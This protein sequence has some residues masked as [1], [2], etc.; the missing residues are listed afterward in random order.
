MV[1]LIRCQL[2]LYNPFF[3]CHFSQLIPP[4]HSFINSRP[5]LQQNQNQRLE[6]SASYLMAAFLVIS[7]LLFCLI[8]TSNAASP[9]YNV[10]QFGAKPDG[11]TDSTQPFL[12]AWVAACTSVQ[13]AM[14]YV[15][16]GRYVIKAAEFRG[17]CKN[18]IT[19]RIDGTLVAPSDF[20]ALG[21]DDHWIL[22][23]DVDRLSV[24]G[25]SFDG[26]GAGLW[27]CRKSAQN[28]PAAARVRTS[29]NLYF[30]LIKYIIMCS[31]ILKRFMMRIN[32]VGNIQLGEQCSSERFNVSKQPRNAPR[33][34]QLQQR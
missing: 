15:P 1:R 5:P 16:K 27:A 31:Y 26:K 13:A 24:L 11:K 23:I 30:I 8:G 25:G 34:Q 32:A 14:I 33:H 22:F 10:L 21:D 7:M 2:S 20:R 9:S 19:V 29:F 28:C 12:K 4:K 3:N 17:P 18:K 6:L